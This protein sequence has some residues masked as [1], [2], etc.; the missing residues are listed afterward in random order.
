MSIDVEAAA[1][2]CISEAIT[3]AVKYSGAHQIGVGLDSGDGGLRFSI[4]DDG[5]GFDPA[6][7]SGGSGVVG[8]RDRLEALGGSL[9]LE[10]APGEGTTV[11]GFVPGTPID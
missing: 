6:T 11:S 2:F 9:S 1:Y 10:S 5:S 3:N 7:T 8:M 4:R